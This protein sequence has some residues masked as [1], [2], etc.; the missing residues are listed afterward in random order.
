MCDG[1]CL[2]NGSP[3]IKAGRSDSNEWTRASAGTRRG[4]NPRARNAASENTGESREG[5]VQRMAQGSDA[6]GPKEKSAGRVVSLVS[7]R[8]AR[9]WC[10]SGIGGRVGG[11]VCVRSMCACL[12]RAATVADGRLAESV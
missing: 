7:E 12:V 1:A 9:G 5:S 11:L 3:T 6:G 4:C 10:V 2:L 8:V